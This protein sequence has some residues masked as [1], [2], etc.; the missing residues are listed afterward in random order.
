[1]WRVVSW[2]VDELAH[3]LLLQLCKARVEFVGHPSLKHVQHLILHGRLFYH[4]VQV[5]WHHVRT[6]RLRLNKHCDVQNK[7]TERLVFLANGLV[8]KILNL[9]ASDFVH[10]IRAATTKHHVEEMP[11]L[12]DRVQRVVLLN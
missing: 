7:D 4:V 10:R 11:S 6:Q 8:E 9:F 5:H 12:E 2:L 1:L 3:S